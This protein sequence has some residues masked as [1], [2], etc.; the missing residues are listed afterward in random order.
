[1]NP[2]KRFPAPLIIPV[3]NQVREL[4]AKLLLS[5]VAAERGFRVIM[6]S[7][8]YIHFKIAAMPRGVYLAKSMRS[9]SNRMF[10]IIRNLGHEIV[11]WDEEAL[12]H[13]PADIYFNLRLTPSLCRKSIRSAR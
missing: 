10:R 7:R 3:E 12:V 13:P 9:L 11:A 5:C 2:M 6:G 4:D 1:M 8:A